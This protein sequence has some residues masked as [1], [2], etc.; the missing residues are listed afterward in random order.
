MTT[1]QNKIIDA[2]K[3]VLLYEGGQSHKITIQGIYNLLQ[4]ESQQN[5]NEAIANWEGV[6][7]VGNSLD[8]VIEIPERYFKE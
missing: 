4:D 8:G 6:E 2:I 5:I 7:I 3:N 1:V